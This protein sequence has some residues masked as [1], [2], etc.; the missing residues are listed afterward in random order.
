MGGVR[1]PLPEGLLLLRGES[2][3]PMEGPSPLL[4]MKQFH[5]LVV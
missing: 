3:V 5:K 1:Q 2:H 4:L